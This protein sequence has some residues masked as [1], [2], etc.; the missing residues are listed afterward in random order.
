LPLD[1]RDRETA[2]FEIHDAPQ[3]VRFCHIN[4]DAVDHR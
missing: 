4:V 1:E 3:I 2:A